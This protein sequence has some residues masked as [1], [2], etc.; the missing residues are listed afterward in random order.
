[1]AAP[2][3][4][5]STAI[6][7]IVVMAVC[8]TATV[9][10]EGRVL[11]RPP[12]PR[13]CSSRRTATSRASG[14]RR[15]AVSS[16]ACDSPTTSCRSTVSTS[17]QRTVKYA[18]R[19]W[20]RVVDDAA[21]R[22]HRVG[23]RARRDRDRARASSTCASAARRSKLVALR[24]HTDLRRCAVRARRRSSPWSRAPRAA[25]A[26]VREVRP[27]RGGIHADALRRAHHAR[28]GADLSRFVR[29]AALR[30]DGARASP[31]GR[32]PRHPASS[33]ARCSRSTP[34][35]SRSPP[36]S[37]ARDCG[38]GAGDR[39]AVALHDAPRERDV[40][41]RQRARRAVLACA[42]HPA[43]D[44]PRHLPRDGDPLPAP[45]LRRAAHDC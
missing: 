23:A 27:D 2:S 10:S 9:A 43:R 40:P 21:A 13:R 12:V 6:V 36:S 5:S 35:G 11:V 26:D 30:A 39:A 33:M 28:D 25:R 8:V 16:K 41:V 22:G 3:T 32:R 44:A 34:A 31:P 45:R 38:R 20:D 42:G 18:A 1:M 4:R 17:S 37:V 29:L 19:A 24:R 14:C 7:A 15:G